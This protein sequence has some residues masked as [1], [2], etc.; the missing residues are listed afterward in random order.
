MARLNDE[1]RKNLVAYLDGELDAK[2]SLDLETK[3]N[4]DPAARAEVDALKQAWEMLDYLPRAEP[5]ATFTHR[6]LERL[7][8]KTSVVP[9]ARTGPLLGRWFR[10]T[11]AAGIVLALAGG[12]AATRLFSPAPV[13]SPEVEQHLVRHLRALEKVRLLE[14][15]DDLR[16]VRDLDDPDL[17][18][19]EPGS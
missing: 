16:F 11:W 15:A 17:F 8:L 1:E 5:S 7:A 12:F 2:T 13:D 6:T 4:L 9:Q 3:L 18:G 10:I 19:D 14:Q